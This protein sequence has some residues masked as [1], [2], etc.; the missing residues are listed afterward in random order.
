MEKEEEEKLKLSNSRKLYI[1][2]Y[3]MVLTI[4][5]VIIYLKL[6]EKTIDPLAIKLTIAFVIISI[7]ATEIHR[8]GNSYEIND[9]SVIHSQGYFTIKSKKI[10]FGA[11]SDCDVI[12][13]IWQRIF[14]YGN[15]EIHMYSR[16]STAHIKNINNPRQ[17]TDFLQG[18]MK[19]S[20]GRQR[21]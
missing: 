17:F 4:I 20:G 21:G 19:K 16:E 15:I 6:S 12:Q 13:N 10:E 11:I 14:G 1:P 5:G 2:I 18:K 9:K 8:L 7:I 3:L